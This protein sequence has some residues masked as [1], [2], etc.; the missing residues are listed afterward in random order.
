LAFTFVE[1]NNGNVMETFDLAISINPDAAIISQVYDSGTEAAGTIAVENT[2]GVNAALFL[3]ADWG[4]TAP[5]TDREATLLANALM[6]SVVVSSDDEAV[7]T[8]TFYVGR[9]IDLIDVPVFNSLGAGNQ[10]DVHVSVTLP[11]THS[12]PAL[13]DK[14]LVSDLVFVAVSVA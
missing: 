6:V 1:N 8:S 14:R 9:L 2:G 10:A 4:A 11:D 13:L 12:G 3:T 7:P 5:T